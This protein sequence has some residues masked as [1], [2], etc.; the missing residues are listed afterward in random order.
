[1]KAIRYIS[2]FSVGAAALAGC[3]EVPDDSTAF[4][5]HNLEL[6][7]DT[8]ADTDVGGFHFTATEVDCATGLPVVPANIVTASEDLED[9][10]FPGA[11]SIFEDAPYDADS[12]HLF[13]D[14]FF[15]LPEGCYDILVQ[16]VTADGE[17]SEDCASAS[18]SGVS[19]TDGA[20]TEVVLISQCEGDLGGG[21]DVVAT[22]NHPPQI[23]GLTYDPSKFICEDTTTVC[24]TSWDP[25][26]DP[27]ESALRISDGVTVVW[28][29]TSTSDEGLTEWCY[30]LAFDGP[31][32]YNIGFTVNDMGY[33]ADGNPVTIASL[34]AAQGDPSSSN[35]FISFPVHVLAEDDCIS[36]CECPDGYE[37]TPAG[38]EC[39]RVDEAEVIWNGIEYTVCEGDELDQYGMWGARYPGGLDF[40]TS[41]FQN[42]LNDVG[43]WA[44]GEP[45]W[46]GTPPLGEW[47]G[48]TVCLDIE[49][50]G[51]YLVG[52]AA[53][54]RIRFRVNG[55]P[56][57]TRDNSL[58]DNFRRWW[59]NPVSLG[60]GLNIIEIE[61]RNDSAW[62]AFGAD[63]YGP[64][65]SGSLA[66]DTDMSAADVEGNVLW[67]TME[68]LGLPFIT[69]EFSGYS[70]PDGFAMNTCTGEITCTRIDRVP[71]E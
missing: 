17:I 12:Q 62:A 63:V 28:T 56:F 67:S 66:T 50:P 13:S 64:F 18:L 27:L 23:V 29:S 7:F 31:G 24:I 59:M 3:A 14:H 1:M 70:C 71:C 42:R 40:V 20:T 6:T 32:D 15:W 69:G 37:L 68:M 39:I 61:G 9:M 34:L 35:D 43:V 30:E 52:M 19:V 41:F 51:D 44:C 46:T 58:N 47:V 36:F 10:Y 48:F 65:A 38:D 8:L 49:E 55:A 60:S 16:P 25:D 53:D 26:G 4:D 11:G 33:D 21:L 45:G 2:L 22:I 54:N 5:S 57:F